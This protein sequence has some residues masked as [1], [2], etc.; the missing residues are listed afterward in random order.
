MNPNT[1]IYAPDLRQISVGELPCSQCGK[2]LLFTDETALEIARGSKLI[3]LSCVGLT[4]GKYLRV[5]RLCRKILKYKTRRAMKWSSDHHSVCRGC[6]KRKSV[7]K[8]LGDPDHH[9][10]CPEGVRGR[11]EAMGEAGDQNRKRL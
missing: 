9:V 8:A 10:G 5:C 2:P 6:S 4:E 3:C 7:Y 11:T 1:I